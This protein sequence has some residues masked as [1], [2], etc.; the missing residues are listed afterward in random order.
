MMFVLGFKGN[1][2]AWQHRKF[3]SVEE[4]KLIQKKWSILGLVLFIIGVVFTVFFMLFWG[5]IFFAL[6]FGGAMSSS[7]TLENTSETNV[8][9]FTNDK[10]RQLDIR[11]LAIRVID[12]QLD[13]ENVQQT[14]PASLA[15][16]AATDGI[17]LPSDPVSGDNYEYITD[18]E[19]YA[20][21]ARLEGTA[22]CASKIFTISD[23]IEICR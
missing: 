15:E 5:A 16:L 7:S 4:F 6:I 8:E 22:V 1:E 18:G 10:L 9:R 20:L 13:P 11:D 19:S 17:A 21:T 12:Y 14:P 23:D 2:W 3:A